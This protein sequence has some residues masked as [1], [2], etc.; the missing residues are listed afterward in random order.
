MKYRWS[1]LSIFVFFTFCCALPAPAE[2]PN[3]IGA[4]AGIPELLGVKYIREFNKTSIGIS[5]G[6]IPNQAVIFPG[7]LIGYRLVSSEVVKV[8]AVFATAYWPQIV[9]TNPPSDRDILHLALRPEVKFD[10]HRIRFGI[11]AGYDQVIEFIQPLMSLHE[12][13]LSPFPAFNLDIGY[14]F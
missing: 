14:L 7:L 1:F 2:H 12:L 6:Y 3:F 13:R 9:I 8:D 10:L 5:I 4:T 11:G